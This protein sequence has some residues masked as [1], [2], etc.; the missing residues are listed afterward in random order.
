MKCTRSGRKRDIRKVSGTATTQHKK[1]GKNLAAPGSHI[2]WLRRRRSRQ[3][4]GT[5][6]RSERRASGATSSSSLSLRCCTRRIENRSFLSLSSLSQTWSTRCPVVSDN[7][8]AENAGEMKDHYN[9]TLFSSTD[10]TQGCRT[11]TLCWRRTGPR[12]RKVRG[13][14]TN[15]TLPVS[16]L[17][18][19]TSHLV[20]FHRFISFFS[21]VSKMN[22]FKLKK[23]KFLNWVGWKKESSTQLFFHFHN[24]LKFEKEKT[25]KEIR[26]THEHQTS[27]LRF[28]KIE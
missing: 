12:R 18:S 11:S 9:I 13:T 7:P 20:S 17:P 25:S 5:G 28:L 8:K 2:F 1:V 23:I 27:N 26:P 6:C 21:I 3:T 16:C 15:E 10:G 24:F 19:S 4:R 22:F 14:R